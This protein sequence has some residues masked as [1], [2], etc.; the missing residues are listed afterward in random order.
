MVLMPAIPFPMSGSTTPEPPIWL[1][2]GKASGE[3]I[4]DREIDYEGRND[5]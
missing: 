4:S 3:R 2:A 1:D 5:D